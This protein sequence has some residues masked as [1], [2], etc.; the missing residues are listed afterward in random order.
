MWL[1]APQISCRCGQNTAEMNENKNSTNNLSCS[2]EY[3]SFRNITSFPLKVGSE[4]RPRRGCCEYSDY[5]SKFL[6]GN[7]RGKNLKYT[8]KSKIL[9]V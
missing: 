4:V 6:E 1:V 7:I 8:V 3:K 2:C 9:F 5:N